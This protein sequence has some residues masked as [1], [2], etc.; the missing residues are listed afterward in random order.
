MLAVVLALIVAVVVIWLLFA[1]L[2]GSGGSSTTNVTNVNPP[3]QT[4][5]ASKDGAERQHQRAEGRR[6]HAGPAAERAAA[7]R[8][9]QA[10]TIT[11]E[12]TREAA[13]IGAASFTS[14]PRR[15]RAAQTRNRPRP[16]RRNSLECGQNP[17]GRGAVARPIGVEARTHA[18]GVRGLKSTSTI[19]RRCATNETK[20]AS[21]SD[22]TMVDV[23]FNPRTLAGP[24]CHAGPHGFW[25]HSNELR[26]YR[27]GEGRRVSSVSPL[28]AG[29]GP[30]VR[31]YLPVQI[32][33]ERMSLARTVPHRLEWCRGLAV[34]IAPFGHGE[35]RSPWSRQTA[36][37]C[38]PLTMRDGVPK[39]MMRKTWK[40]QHVR[41]PF[42]VI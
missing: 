5:P 35:G 37:G 34:Q 22:R 32:W 17:W 33:P 13:P 6:E 2:F 10:L 31:S 29:E 20:P 1:G 42:V 4:Q 40:G 8:A 7:G 12:R 24:M 11:P 41:S 3:A 28:R 21:R 38:G 19:G 36:N 39:S 14:P 30:G 25:S 16:R 26:P 23:G 15:Q 27:R 18:P 9:R